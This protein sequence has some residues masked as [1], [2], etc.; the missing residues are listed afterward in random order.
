MR[1]AKKRS[2]SAAKDAFVATRRVG[3]GPGV[4]IDSQRF[5]KKEDM[6]FAIAGGAMGGVGESEVYQV[7]GVR[8]GASECAVS[9]TFAVT[10]RCPAGA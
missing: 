9:Y 10:S 3:V 2:C 7:V 5:S 4:K 1:R 8:C 6:V